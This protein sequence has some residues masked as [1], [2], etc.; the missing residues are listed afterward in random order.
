M[1]NNGKDQELQRDE[2]RLDTA[3]SPPIKKLEYHAPRLIEYGTI[4]KLT[5][6]GG[7]GGADAMGSSPCL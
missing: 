7:V 2:P 6:N 3:Q 5:Q 4:A 1:E